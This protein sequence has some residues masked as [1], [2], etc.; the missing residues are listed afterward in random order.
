M[1]SVV[2]MISGSGPGTNRYERGRCGVMGMGP[3]AQ[4]LL[5]SARLRW[6]WFSVLPSKVHTLPIGGHRKEGRGRTDEGCWALYLLLYIY[7]A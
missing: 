2:L 3:D 4:F 6:A 5:V 1:S 7:E